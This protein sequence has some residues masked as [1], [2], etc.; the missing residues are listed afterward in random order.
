MDGAARRSLASLSDE[1]RGSAGERAGVSTSACRWEPPGFTRR[2]NVLTRGG[3]RGSAQRDR[4][5]PVVS[6]TLFGQYR[7]DSEERIG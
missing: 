1:R 4:V 3:R 2:T 6:N 5:S 7:L